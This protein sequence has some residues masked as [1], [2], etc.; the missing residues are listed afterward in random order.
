MKKINLKNVPEFTSGFRTPI[1]GFV[2]EIKAIEDKEEK[3]YLEVRY[4]IVDCY[5][6]NDKEFIGMYTKRKKERDFDLP[7]HIISYSEKSLPFF[8][9]FCTA[10]KESNNGY[11][12]EQTFNEA[13]L[14]GKRFGAVFGEEEY[15]GKDKNGADKVKKRSTIVGRRS[16]EAIKNGEFTIPEL[17]K[18]D[19][20]PN[21]TP[22]PFEQQTA[23]AP[24][25]ESTPAE[26]PF[27]TD[28]PF[29]ASDDTPF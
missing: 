24:T 18:L 8:K 5:D 4:D 6:P 16:V 20:K 19:S 15:L 7:R 29:A 11:D 2:V 12:F 13:E 3:E 17:K 28:N 21:T 23:T 22:N 26:N 27:A 9:G 1:G 14:V 25:E 10:I